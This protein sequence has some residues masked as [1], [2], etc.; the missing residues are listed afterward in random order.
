MATR[1]KPAASAEDTPDA[2]S[3]AVF[4]EGLRPVAVHLGHFSFS[5]VQPQDVRRHGAQLDLAFAEV[6]AVH[7]GI[8][9]PV[10]VR[11]RQTDENSAVTDELQI[12]WSV[13]YQTGV[14]FGT[15]LEDGVYQTALL[16][17]W[18]YARELV[19]STLTR[20]GLPPTQLPIVT[21][22]QAAEFVSGWRSR[23][24]DSRPSAAT[25]SP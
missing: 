18:P 7:D 16:H 14:P 8:V 15:P 23:A 2:S 6:Q 11:L 12:W 5:L 3:W 13:R 19:A 22:Q 17:C 10:S 4:V 21:V 9:V 1:K 20:A 25:A 24:R